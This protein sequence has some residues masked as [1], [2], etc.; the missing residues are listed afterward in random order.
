MIAIAYQLCWL[1]H[2]LIPKT[3]LHLCPS[4]DSNI[5]ALQCAMQNHYVTL[6]LFVMVCARHT[7]D[8][9]RETKSSFLQYQR[10]L[11]GSYMRTAVS[12]LALLLELV[13]DDQ[14]RCLLSA[15]QALPFQNRYKCS[16]SICTRKIEAAVGI[17]NVNERCHGRGEQFK[18]R[19]FES[20]RSSVPPLNCEHPEHSLYFE[21]LTSGGAHI[22]GAA[23]DRLGGIFQPALPGAVGRAQV[24]RAGHQRAQEPWWAERPDLVQQH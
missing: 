21:P 23:A 3:C 24:S 11:G 22:S 16:G 4:G 2:A 18:V 7:T 13:S 17:H 15:Q 10:G 9:E 8:S 14:V 12:T 5:Q 19:C 20:G 6:A 1:L